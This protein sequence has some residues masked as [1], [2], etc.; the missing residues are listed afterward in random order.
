VS[1][2]KQFRMKLSGSVYRAKSC[3]SV[4]HSGKFLFVGSDT[5]AVGCIV[6]PQNAPKETSRRKREPEFF[7]IDNQAYTGRVTFR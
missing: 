4:F 6:K 2:A 5:F 3:T 1:Q 7:D